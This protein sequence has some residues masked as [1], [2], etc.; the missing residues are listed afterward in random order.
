MI[1]EKGQRPEIYYYY[2]LNV[3][4]NIIQNHLCIVKICTSKS[5]NKIEKY[6]NIISK[7]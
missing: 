6:V 4:S 3:T 5:I 7:L 1:I 2:F